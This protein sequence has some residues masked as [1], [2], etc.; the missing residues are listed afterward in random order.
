MKRLAV[1]EVPD[2]RFLQE[3]DRD[4]HQAPQSHEQDARYEQRYLSQFRVALVSSFLQVIRSL[5]SLRRMCFN[6]VFSLNVQIIFLSISVIH[7]YF[8]FHFCFIN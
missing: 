7:F 4:R 2:L 1:S 3:G 6:S 8:Y 5:F